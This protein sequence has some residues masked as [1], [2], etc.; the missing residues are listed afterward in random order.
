MT[1]K[2]NTWGLVTGDES[3]MQLVRLFFSLYL[4][5]EL[6]LRYP[7]GLEEKPELCDL[8]N[9]VAAKIP[10]KWRQFGIELQLTSDELDG[11]LLA[12]FGDTL[13]CFSSVFT[14]WQKRMSRE[15]YSWLTV[16][17]S[18]KAPAVGEHRLAQELNH[19][20]SLQLHSDM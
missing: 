5:L 20:F 7:A 3:G 9:E 12:N 16:V 1:A 10:S 8:M 15:P 4:I 19:K 14:C 2:S 6:C 18:L 11:F 13:R 17:E